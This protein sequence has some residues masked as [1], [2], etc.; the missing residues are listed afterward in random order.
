VLHKFAFFTFLLFTERHYQTEQ[1]L[2]LKDFVSAVWHSSNMLVSLNEVNL[3]QVS[4]GMGD[5]VRVKFPVPDIY[6]GM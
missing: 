3:S 6:L 4:T 2:N 1:Q 5:R